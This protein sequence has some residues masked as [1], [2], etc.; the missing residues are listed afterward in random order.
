MNSLQVFKH[1][2]HWYSLYSFNNWS[3]LLSTKSLMLFLFTSVWEDWCLA[4]QLWWLCKLAT[5]TI[6][7]YMYS[8][9]MFSCT[10]CSCCVFHLLTLTPGCFTVSWQK[11]AQQCEVQ[12]VLCFVCD[13]L[14]VLGFVFVCLVLIQAFINSVAS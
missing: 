1:S 6:F 14:F 2:F 8:H 7:V 3:L 5:W 9:L 10:V 12:L 11:A 13:F 4:E